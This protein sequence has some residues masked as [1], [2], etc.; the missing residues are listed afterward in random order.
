MSYFCPPAWPTYKLWSTRKMV[1]TCRA[2]WRGRKGRE[3]L[4]WQFVCVEPKLLLRAEQCKH[5]EDSWVNINKV[6]F[7][8]IFLI[9]FLTVSTEHWQISTR[10]RGFVHQLTWTS[11]LKNLHWR[12]FQTQMLNPSRAGTFNVVHLLF[13]FIIWK[14]SAL[15][16]W[17]HKNLMVKSSYWRWPSPGCGLVPTPTT[18][19]TV[20][21]REWDS[22]GC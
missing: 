13:L 16:V 20:A 1:K 5:G 19:R 21:G 3:A 12:L 14:Q 4:P 6:K 18:H 10:K 7:K 15:I 2:A 22:P 8:W 9:T 17:S 11:W